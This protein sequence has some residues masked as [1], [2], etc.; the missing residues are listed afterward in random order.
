MSVTYIPAALRRL[1]T[2]RASNVCEY[3][4][5]PA[6]ASFYG[7]EI[8][9]IISE[10]HGGLTVAANLALACFVCNRNKGSDVATLDPATSA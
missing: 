1:V 8:D 4:R 2:A 3:C 7:C 5:L 9:H 10:K 6:A